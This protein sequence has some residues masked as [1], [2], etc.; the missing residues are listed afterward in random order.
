MV[1]GPVFALLVLCFLVPLALVSVSRWFFLELPL[2]WCC[3]WA[4]WS[5]A[6]PQWRD[7]ALAGG[8]DPDQLQQLGE[9]AK[10]VWPKGHLAERTEIHRDRR[11][12]WDRNRRVERK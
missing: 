2:L 9:A 6:V 4:W 11:D 12:Y 3:A 10:L 8:A 5:Y 1:N 7:W